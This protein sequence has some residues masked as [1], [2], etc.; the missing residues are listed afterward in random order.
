MYTITTVFL[1]VGAINSQNNLLFWAFGLAVAGMLVSGIVSGASLMGIEVARDPIETSQVHGVMRIRYRV[2]NSNRVFPAFSI[3]LS[4]R[5]KH[6]PD[7]ELGH[8]A[9]WLGR[10]PEPFAF[11]P[12]V[13]A[14]ET[15]TVEAVVTPIRRGEVRFRCVSAWSVFPFGLTRKS[16]SFVGT[17]TALVRPDAADSVPD[18]ERDRGSEPGGG[19]AA[20]VRSPEGQD[21]FALREYSPGDSPR[22]ISWRHTARTGETI[23]RQNSA[24][25]NERLW[26]VLELDGDADLGEK[27]IRVAAA[28]VH[29]AAERNIQIGLLVPSQSLRAPPREGRGHLEAILDTLAVIPAVAS[30]GVRTEVAQ[31]SRR[32]IA[33]EWTYVVSKD[34]PEGRMF[35]AVPGSE[36]TRSPVIPIGGER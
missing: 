6:P 12:L 20:P 26:V 18:L 33:P 16:V 34:A 24:F 7:R 9:N 29:R 22:A 35:R 31:V 11:V 23:V 13:R 21:F 19:R 5:P 36:P 3:N 4:E 8:R 32:I 2:R 10:V 15:V 30:D 25:A 28:A 17:R 1:A 27:L 14:G